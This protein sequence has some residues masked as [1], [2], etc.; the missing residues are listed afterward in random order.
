MLAAAPVVGVSASAWADAPKPVHREAPVYPRGAE[1]RGIEGHVIVEYTV[2]SEG[3]ITDAIVLEAAPEGVFDAAAV[4]AVQKWRYEKSGAESKGL[5][6]KL[7]FQ[8]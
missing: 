5:Q 3:E 7:T 1:R 6:T 2:T 4:Q 8:K